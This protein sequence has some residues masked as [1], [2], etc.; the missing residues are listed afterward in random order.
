MKNYSHNEAL[1]VA[2]MQSVNRWVD[3][4]AI[5]YFTKIN[6]KSECYP[7]HSRAS[8]LRI[9]YGYKDCLFNDVSLVDGV[10]HSKY[11]LKLSEAEVLVI[12][13]LWK[14]HKKI[15]KYN[16][17]QSELKPTIENQEKEEEIKK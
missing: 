15:P 16:Q 17:V 6:C 3:I 1:F 4:T 11:M 8:D 12:R 13:E 2:L 9:K 7:V 10:N 5:R 14:K